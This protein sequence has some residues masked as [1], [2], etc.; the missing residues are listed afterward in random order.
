MRVAIVGCGHV[1]ATSAYL[2]ALKGVPVTL[3]DIVEGLPQGTALDML[4]SFPLLGIEANLRGTNDYSQIAG[5]DLVV[6]TAGEARRPGMSRTDLLA[7]NARMVGSVVGEIQKYAPSA[8]IMVVTNPL[9]VMTFLVLRKSKLSPRRVFGMGGTLDSSRMGYFTADVL[10]ASVK[11]ISAMVVGSHGDSMVPLPRFTL[12]GGTPLVD[13]AGPREISEIVTR[14]RSAGAEIVSYL[15]TGSA[16]YAPAAAVAEM[17][18]SVLRDEK[19]VF[20]S[21]VFLEGQYGLSD[22]CLSV[23]VKLGAQG[24]EE[25]VELDLNDEEREALQKSAQ[26]VREGIRELRKLY[27]G[28]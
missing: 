19:Q 4:Q 12:V 6:L 2:L 8:L 22:V 27:P 26:E 13:V 9:D 28:L 5:V 3:L 14:T 23:P 25:I 20:S 15:K 16:F 1:G 24:V 21:C 7:K 11:Q 10:G 18:E 17:A